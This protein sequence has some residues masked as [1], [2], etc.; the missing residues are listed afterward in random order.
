MLGLGCARPVRNLALRA[1][2]ATIAKSGPENERVMLSLEDDI[3]SG[4]QEKKKV[5]GEG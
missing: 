2:R 3:A 4:W 1:M 5:A